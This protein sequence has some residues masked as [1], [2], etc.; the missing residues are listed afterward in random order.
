MAR[1]RRPAPPTTPS[2]QHPFLSEGEVETAARVLLD[3]MPPGIAEALRDYGLDPRDQIRFHA[4]AERCR[5]TREAR[6]LSVKEVAATLRSTQRTIN[7]IEK[8]QMND[9]QPDVL[10][11]YA[12][13]LGIETWLTEWAAHYGAFGRRI[14]GA[15]APE[16]P[17]R[18]ATRRRPGS[19]APEFTHVLTLDVELSDVEP[20]VWRRIEVPDTYSF[21]EL[22]VAIQ[23]AMGWQDYHL[24]EFRVDRGGGRP[25]RIGFPDDDVPA[26]DD[27]VLGWFVAVA[28]HL[29]APGAHV[30]YVYD[31]GD[32]W[33]HD[34]RFVAR[35]PRVERTAYPRCMDG[36]RACPPE[37][38]G[39]VPG[40]FDFLCAIRDSTHEEHERMIEWSGG[41]YDPLAFDPRAVRF[42]DPRARWRLAMA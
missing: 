11:R 32:G 33:R 3:A 31:F 23:D 39:G 25:L 7:A 4:V 28:D 10:Q 38:V 8:S 30:R 24:H 22:H 15:G 37:D 14:V 26:E 29:G 40:Y 6:G 19:R 20:R 9:V 18:R 35:A 36:A 2:H 21:Y 1:T 5:T 27:T 13:L 42:D 41:R 12:A 17:V 16:R 34:V